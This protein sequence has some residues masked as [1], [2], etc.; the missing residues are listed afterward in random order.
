MCIL[1]YWHTHYCGREYDIRHMLPMSVSLS[2][3][4][5]PS[6]QVQF[7]QH[8]LQQRCHHT[9]PLYKITMVTSHFSTWSPHHLLSCWPTPWS[10]IAIQS[11]HCYGFSSPQRW[12][13]L[14]QLQPAYQS[15]MALDQTTKVTNWLTGV[16]G[17]QS[18]VM[19]ANVAQPYNWTI[20]CSS[21][22]C[23]WLTMASRDWDNCS[24]NSGTR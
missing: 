15:V 8:R 18:A 13:L 16:V 20:E 2:T 24:F 6:W 22:S 23:I 19:A 17:L 1:I 9:C 14:H 11:Y 21:K 7:G 3:A 4:W 5:M 12:V 10:P